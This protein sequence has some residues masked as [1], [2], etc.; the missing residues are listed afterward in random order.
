MKVLLLLTALL[1]LTCLARCS[2]VDGLEEIAKADFYRIEGIMRDLSSWRDEANGG[3]SSRPFVTLTFAQTLNGQIALSTSSATSS[4]SSSANFPLSGSLSRQL[5]HGLRSIHDGILVGGNTLSIDNPRLSNRLWG[6]ASAGEARKQFAQPRPVVLDTN[7]KHFLTVRTK[8]RTEGRLIVCCSE[9][10]AASV[11]LDMPELL[12]DARFEL[13]PCKVDNSGR[14][15]LNHTLTQLYLRCGIKSLMVEGGSAVITSFLLA[16]AYDA[17]CV[18]IAPKLILKGGLDAVS[19]SS[20]SPPGAKSE[21]SWVDWST[22]SDSD[23]P[24][25]VPLGE[26][27]VF[28]ARQRSAS[29]LPNHVD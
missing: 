20:L 9:A 22:P 19:P 18:T 4:S 8:L 1:L 23:C 11:S 5:T 13:L 29:S 28:F 15:N 16:D 14:L 21:S 3:A 12:E 25:F 17:L 2:A 26:D 6:S 27:C 24:K 10:A 7:L